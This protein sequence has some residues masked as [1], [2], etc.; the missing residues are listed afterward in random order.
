[1]TV[2]SKVDPEISNLVTLYKNKPEE[3]QK[4]I[5]EK[6]DTFPYW[7]TK[8]IPLRIKDLIAFFPT[9]L[10]VSSD[11]WEDAI[12]NQNPVKGVVVS[13]DVMKKPDGTYSVQQKS[14]ME[15]PDDVL[16]RIVGF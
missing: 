1:M 3:F 7:Q 6:Y 10:F 13:V 9:W 5:R 15:E 8:N 16:K 11:D 12:I 4:K 14:I 2:S